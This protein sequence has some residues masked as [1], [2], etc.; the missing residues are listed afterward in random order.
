MTWIE[1]EFVTRCHGIHFD[2]RTSQTSWTS[3]DMLAS[4]R[5]CH[6]MREVEVEAASGTALHVLQSLVLWQ[7]L[8]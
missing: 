1:F 2:A 3:F 7:L 4:R 6:G 8:V 5:S